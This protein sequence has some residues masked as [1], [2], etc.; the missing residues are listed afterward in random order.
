MVTE[1]IT[2]AARGC[3]ESRRVLCDGCRERELRRPER[4]LWLVIWAFVG[5]FIGKAI[6]SAYVVGYQVGRTAGEQT[7][8]QQ[9]DR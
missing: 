1:R 9:G 4:V 3:G 8:V 7:I 2:M 5:L 6:V